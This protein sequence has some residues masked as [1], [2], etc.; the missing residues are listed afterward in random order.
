MI[1][2]DFNRKDIAWATAISNLDDDCEFIEAT[3]DS[4][5]TQ[6][7]STPTRGR[8]TNDPSLIDLVFTSN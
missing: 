1:I 4:F 3:R 5:L 8:G 2:G 6:P 7:V